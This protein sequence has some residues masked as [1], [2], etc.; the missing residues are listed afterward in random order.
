M[1]FEDLVGFS[2]ED[3]DD[4]ASRFVIEG[5]Y[6][7]STVNGRRM[8]YGRFETPTLA[9]LRQTA[10]ASAIAEPGQLTLSE[11]VGDVRD[12]HAEPANANAVFQVASQFNTLEMISPSVRPEDGI[13]IYE[14]DHTQG[15]ACAIA[16]GAGTIFRNYLVSF[17][18]KGVVTT[19]GD[20]VG[21][22]ANRQVNC[23]SDLLQALDVPVPIANGY[24]LPTTE[25]L[26]AIDAR[27]EAIAETERDDLLAQLR[28][29]VQWNTEV[30]LSLPHT[31]DDRERATV[32]QVFGSALPIAYS[33]VDPAL[34]ERFAQLV[35]DASY[36]AVFRVACLNAASTN[37]NQLFLTLLGGGA[38]GNRSSWIEAA[39]TRSLEMFA[40]VD[41]QVS[42]VS[43]G[44]SSPTAQRLLS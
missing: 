28:V 41:L 34:W 3:V 43:Y 5:E 20:A 23:L 21:Q 26:G 22:T 35:L 29:G 6:L 32:T 25:Q 36:E 8:R 37:N 30:T 40:D 24:A 9:E 39:I 27:L 1:W 18:T 16:C 7:T 19:S 42:I 10:D 2:E 17:D 31:G 11:I 4:V 14:H 15:P 12:L 38:F 13:G 44:S 33:S